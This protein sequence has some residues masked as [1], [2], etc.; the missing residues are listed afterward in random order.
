MSRPWS[1]FTARAT[2]V[3]LLS[4]GVA[5]GFYLS[6]DR[7]S[8][9]QG[10]GAQVAGSVTEIDVEYRQEPQQ[11]SRQVRAAREQATE[12][13]KRARA[14][15][16]KARKAEEA[17][18]KKAEEE[19]KAREEAAAARAARPYDGPIP[20]SCAEYSGNRKVGCAMMI[21][22]GFKI[23]QFPCLDKLWNKESGWNHKARNPSSGAYGIPQAY[24]GNKMAS[25]GSDWQTNPVTQITWG[26][27]YIKGRY[28]NPCGAWAKSQSSGYY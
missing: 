5:G 19:R 23:D 20:A 9:R 21:D 28:S 14:A 16:E 18:R 15:A 12:T 22:A 3:A 6:E 2:A 17:A 8:Q 25:V 4:M 13:R 7:Q 10:P 26:L 27:G 11:V 24:P 1:R